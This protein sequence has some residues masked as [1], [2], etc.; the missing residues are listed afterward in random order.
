MQRERP[1]FL[2]LRKKTPWAILWITLLKLGNPFRG[3]HSPSGHSSTWGSSTARGGGSNWNEK[4]S[5]IPHRLSRLDHCS[6]ADHEAQRYCDYY[7]HWTRF[8]DRDS[9]RRF[10]AKPLSL[11]TACSL[12]HPGKSLCRLHSR[13][14]KL[15][16]ERWGWQAIEAFTHKHAWHPSSQNPELFRFNQPCHLVPRGFNIAGF[17]LLGPWVIKELWFFYLTY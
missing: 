4:T 16:L 7:Y 3:T 13:I 10:C 12:L 2:R 9:P 1:L 8:L 14:T 17:G 15:W 6:R 5:S 11:A